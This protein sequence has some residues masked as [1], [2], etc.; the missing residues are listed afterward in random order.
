MSET[1][2]N[3][4]IQL[5]A[6]ALG[7][8]AAASSLKNINLGNL[9]NTVAGALGGL[10]GGQILE[11]LIPGLG[12]GATGGGLDIGTI[13]GQL[14]GGGAGGAVLTIIAGLVRNMLQQR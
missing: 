4:I 12:A 9:G 8:N 10:G 14:V 1:A 2:I 6:G 5:I 7:G 3:L 13:I 11:G